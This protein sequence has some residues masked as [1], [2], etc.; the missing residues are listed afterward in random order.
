MILF[1]TNQVIRP[2]A[3]GDKMI[4][5]TE[6]YP[7]LP[8][9]A[10]KEYQELIDN[11]KDKIKKAAEEAISDLYCEVGTHIET[12]AWN[13]FRNTI[14]SG[15]KGYPSHLRYDFKKIRQEI[16]IENRADIIKEL[17]Q[18]LVEEV[19]TLKKDLIRAY[20]SNY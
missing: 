18:D 4:N 6:I 9:Q 8:E 1:I 13:N 11:A 20:S 5:E 7:Y 15:L 14:I 16:L 3:K 10:K 17:N 19:E 2:R 12:D